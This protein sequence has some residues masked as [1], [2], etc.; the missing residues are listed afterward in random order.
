M[1][2]DPMAYSAGLGW[3]SLACLKKLRQR[4]VE[5][6]KYGGPEGETLLDLWDA[7]AMAA[8][9]ACMPP[10]G[11]TSRRSPVADAFDVADTFLAM[12]AARLAGAAVAIE[13]D[14]DDHDEQGGSDL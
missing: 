10:A 8:L 6:K 11:E 13:E 9:P 2:G 14:E 1:K 7:V 12:R 3:G 5:I 4:V